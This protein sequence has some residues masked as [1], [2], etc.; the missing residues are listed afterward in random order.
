MRKAD[1]FIVGA[2]KCGTTAWF[3]YL[4][5]HPKIFFPEMKEPHYFAPD[6]PNREYIRSLD[7]YQKLFSSAEDSSVLG[8]ASVLYLYSE[9]AARLIAEYNPG[10]RILIFLRDQ[11]DMLVSW[12]H[13]L[14]WMFSESLDDFAEAWRLSG[15]RLPETISSH[16]PN[17][18]LLD[19][20]AIGSFHEQIERYLR[21]F[22][23]AQIRIFHYREWTRNPRE[24]YLKILDLL[25]LEDDGR[26]EF[27]PINDAKAHR[28]PW[29]GRLIVR[30]PAF[31]EKLI[32]PVRRLF[33][34]QKLRLAER[35]AMLFASRDRQPPIDPEL[36]EEIR[37]YY[38]VDN[39]LVERL[40][41]DSG[42]SK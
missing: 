12:Y 29:L 23:P 6:M 11:E 16:C 2:P 15:K 7:D 33:G 38:Q 37:R 19:Y 39:Q 40:C 26:I 5:S 41:T 10:A 32:R 20:A 4:R 9:E 28:I 14:R 31:T 13:Q 35:A 18:K 17:P 27:P 8:D 3:E 42:H 21:Y 30:R 24:T 1:L 34:R 25:G 36:R 22:D